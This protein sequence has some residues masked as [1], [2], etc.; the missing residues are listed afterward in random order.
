MRNDVFKCDIFSYFKKM[1]Y[2][3]FSVAGPEDELFSS[4]TVHNMHFV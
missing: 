3:P 4:Y 2:L 1:C